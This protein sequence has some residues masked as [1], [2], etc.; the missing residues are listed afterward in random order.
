MHC[1]TC[2]TWLQ[3]PFGC[4]FFTLNKAPS[5]QGRFT[6]L[7]GCEDDAG[8]QGALTVLSVNLVHGSMAPLG[9]QQGPV[10]LSCSAQ[11]LL[12]RDFTERRCPLKMK[13][14]NVLCLGKAS[15]SNR[16]LLKWDIVLFPGCR[17][18]YHFMAISVVFGIDLCRAY[19]EY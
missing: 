4:R 17:R 12:L 16:Q 2:D 11:M 13:V 5:V 9:F 14:T 10:L 3:F 15:K 1:T 18:L 19:H 8:E 7:Q 6:V